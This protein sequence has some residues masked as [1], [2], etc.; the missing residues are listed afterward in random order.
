MRTIVYPAVL[1]DTDNGEKGYYTVECKGVPERGFKMWWLAEA[2]C[3][4]EQT[5][6]LAL[7]DVPNNGIT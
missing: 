4:A 6:G 7:Y 3:N 5:L 1:D 2:L